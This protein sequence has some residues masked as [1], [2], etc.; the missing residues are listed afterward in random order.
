MAI[1]LLRTSR[2][3]KEQNFIGLG[4]TLTVLEKADISF[5]QTYEK[6]AEAGESWTVVLNPTWNPSG[7]IGE[8]ITQF[9]QYIG[10]FFTAIWQSIMIPVFFVVEGCT[11]VAQVIGLFLQFVGFIPGSDTGQ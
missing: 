7:G 1:N 2:E 11:A 10:N 8:Q 3:D 6:I 9:F 4:G 5:S